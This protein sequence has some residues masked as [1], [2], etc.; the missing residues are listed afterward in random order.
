MDNRRKV[1]N[2]I[3]D[4]KGQLRLA[5][6]FLI[7]LVISCALIVYL[8]MT[9]S[10]MVGQYAEGAGGGA[11]IEISEIGVRTLWVSIAGIVCLGFLTGV[12]WLQS[13]H[14]IF[15]PMVKINR[16]VDHLFNGEYGSRIQL[17]KYDEFHDLAERLNKLAAK[18][19]EKK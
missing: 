5:A 10:S 9:V 1:S 18:L 12:L 11:I 7:L 2:Y 14:R 16:Q 3:I 6:P 17:R 4:S 8:F 13:S 19:E 15:G